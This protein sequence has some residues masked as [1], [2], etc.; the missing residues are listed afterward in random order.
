M[1]VLLQ[2]WWIS[3]RRFAFLTMLAMAA[4]IALTI[5]TLLYYP[6]EYKSQAKLLLRV[7]H[8]SAT[9]DPTADATGR[10]V[11]I[12]TSREHDVY[13]ELEV[14]RSR[15]LLEMVVD[16][17]GVDYVLNGPP[18]DSQSS[19]EPN[20]LSKAISELKASVA[21]LDPI[22]ERERAIRDLDE[23]F[24][25]TAGK[26][27]SLV[28]VEYRAK[29]P[30][31][32]QRITQ[33]WVD[34]YLKKHNDFHRTDRSLEFFRVQEKELTGLLDSE[35]ERL[36]IAKTEDSLVTVAGQQK[37]L[38]EQLAEVR[39]SQVATGA[40]LAASQS[41]VKSLEALL[42]KTSD[43]L[44][45]D[46][47]S[48]KSNEARDAM[49][50]RL[51]ELEVLEREYTAK[52]KNDH[53]RLDAVRKQLAEAKRIVDSIDSG[54]AEVTSGMNPVYV[55]L[56]QEVLLETAL[57]ESLSDKMK[58]LASKLEELQTEA[59]S[60]NAAE[61]RIAGIERQVQILEQRY[62]AHS[63]RMEQARID[64]S[65]K[66]QQINSVN[67]VQSASFE[68]RPV[69]PNKKAVAALGLIALGGSVFGVP[70][71]LGVVFPPR[72]SRKRG[73]E[74]KAESEPALNTKPAPMPVERTE[75]SFEVPAFDSEATGRQWEEEEVVVGKAR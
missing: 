25:F 54:R 40:G 60:L 53:P 74:K 13:T 43:R 9:M 73:L 52:Y 11:Q 20:A 44:V 14:M 33:A 69:T 41:R 35:Y 12:Q 68:E 49:R 3:V 45:T 37:L 7:G 70:M 50:E 6:R 59:A 32:A 64:Q 63:V 2:Q 34:A 19:K 31:V 29:S 67:E 72:K 15:A 24:G 51:F 22:S 55:R 36:R 47:V 38:E 10:L 71:L 8:E 58:A 1:D 17:V 21:S 18:N 66:E 57:Q 48:G 16:D 75:N 46:E 4:V 23:G 39:R 26:L 56:E 28:D 5:C 27:S 65:L 42:G 61:E 62:A 30:E